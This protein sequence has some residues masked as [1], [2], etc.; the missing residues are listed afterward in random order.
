MSETESFHLLAFKD[1]HDECL[2]R[3][4]PILHGLRPARETLVVEMQRVG[5]GGGT[6]SQLFFFKQFIYTETRSKTKFWSS[7]CSSDFTWMC[8]MKSEG[9]GSFFWLQVSKMRDYLTQNE[10][11]MCYLSRY[12]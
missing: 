3:G 8:L 6:W 7:P 2:P 1:K 11:K 10:C 4:C 12:G 9:H 5:G